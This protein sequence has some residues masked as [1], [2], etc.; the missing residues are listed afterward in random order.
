[1]AVRLTSLYAGYTHKDVLVL[2]CVSGRVNAVAMVRMEVL[3]QLK[4]MDDVRS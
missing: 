3:G 2:I 1:M 4:T